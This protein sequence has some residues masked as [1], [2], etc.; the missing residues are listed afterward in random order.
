MF[1]N[2]VGHRR[3][4]TVKEVMVV[5]V[6]ILVSTSLTNQLIDRNHSAHSTVEWNMLVFRAMPQWPFRSLVGRCIPRA[7]PKP[8]LTIPA[9]VIKG[10]AI[11][12]DIIYS[13][14]IVLGLMR[15]ANPVN[16]DCS[17]MFI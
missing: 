2:D 1:S 6:A 3:S 13:S 5:S 12:I 9:K 15:N 7:E 8:S 14:Q 11:L 16:L 4:R 10:G 17:F